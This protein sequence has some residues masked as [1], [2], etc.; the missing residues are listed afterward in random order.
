MTSTTKIYHIQLPEEQDIDSFADLFSFVEHQGIEVLD[1]SIKIYVLESEEQEL[2]DFIENIETSSELQ[3]SVEILEEKNWN[4][5][6]EQSFQPV[7][8][9]N[10]VGVRANFHP[11]FEDVE[12]DLIINPKMSFGTGHHATTRQVMQLMNKTGVYGKKVLDCGSGTGILSILAVK[13]GADKVIAVDNDPWCYENHLE[14]NVLN[15]ADNRVILG[16]LE[17]IAIYNFDL[18]LANIQKNYLL[19]NMKE[20][21]LRVQAGGELIVSGFFDED[22]KEILDE[23]A[24]YDLTAKYISTQDRWSCILFTKNNLHE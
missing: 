10:F 1:E 20:L 16:Q 24:L 3:Y 21:A 6:W 2:F 19:E 8:I 5:E 17:D 13:M 22:N 11:P 9:D 12:Y 15:H 7:R 4:E 14:N 23:A 18:V